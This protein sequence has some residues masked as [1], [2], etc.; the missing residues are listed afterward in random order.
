MLR[1]FSFRTTSVAFAASSTTIALNNFACFRSCS[2]SSS[3]ST[4]H[5]QQPPPES[6]QATPGPYRKVGNVFLCLCTDIPAKYTPQ[7]NKIL[8]E[9]RFE[10]RGQLTAH[11]DTPAVREKLFRVRHIVKVEMISTDEMKESLNI[12][13]HVTFCDLEAGG[14]NRFRGTGPSAKYPYVK[15]MIRFANFRKQRIQDILERDQ[16]EIKLVEAKKNLVKK[17]AAGEN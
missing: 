10:F 4:E 14:L 3:T 7:I 12:P 16:V 13:E 5:Q 2:S 1:N 9:L 17:N 6:Q 15:S 8:R 11:P